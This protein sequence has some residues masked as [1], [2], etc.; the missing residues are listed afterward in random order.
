MHEKDLEKWIEENFSN[1]EEWGLDYKGDGD[2][3]IWFKDIYFDNRYIE[4]LREIMDIVEWHVEAVEPSPREEKADLV[5]LVI[6]GF[7]R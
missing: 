1:V 6:S 7:L 3:E 4:K 2:V 5:L